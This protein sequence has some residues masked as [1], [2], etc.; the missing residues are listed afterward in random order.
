MEIVGDV[1]KSHTSLHPQFFCWYFETHLDGGIQ[2][3][4]GWGP[5]QSDLVAGN[6]ARS[7]EVET[8]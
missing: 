3:L 5:G 4:V 2:D 1:P 6:P 8:G 7:R